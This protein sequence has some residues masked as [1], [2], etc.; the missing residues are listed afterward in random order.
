MARYHDRYKLSPYLK[1][2]AN[3]DLAA[4][5]R[6]QKEERLRISLLGA[7]DAASKVIGSE[8][9]NSLEVGRWMVVA[10]A[11]R[12]L[13]DSVERELDLWV[14]DSEDSDADEEAVADAQHAL[15][16]TFDPDDTDG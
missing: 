10:S 4:Q 13:L 12:A 7:I 14:A 6:K 2:A 3:I 8:A 9:S 5:E 16:V 1:D 15:T 11:A